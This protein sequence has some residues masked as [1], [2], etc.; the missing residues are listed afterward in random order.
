MDCF[1]GMV[2]GWKVRVKRSVIAVSGTRYGSQ[3]LNDSTTSGC[4]CVFPIDVDFPRTNTQSKGWRR[5]EQSGEEMKPVVEPEKP[6][7][8]GG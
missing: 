4:L 6:T 5:V 1:A 8:R 3:Q 2:Q 7:L